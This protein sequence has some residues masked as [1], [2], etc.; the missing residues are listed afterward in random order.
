[1]ENSELDYVFLIEKFI[2]KSIPGYICL[3][4]LEQSKVT[5]TF[6]LPV[7]QGEFL[8]F[9]VQ[10]VFELIDSKKGLVSDNFECGQE[11]FELKLDKPGSIT[12]SKNEQT[13]TFVSKFH[14]LRFVHCIPIMACKAAVSSHL[15]RPLTCFCRSLNN[16]ENWA[17]VLHAE[18]DFALASTILW[19][20]LAKDDND[21]VKTNILVFVEINSKFISSLLRVKK[22]LNE[23]HAQSHKHKRD[24]GVNDG[25][26][27]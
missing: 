27:Q 19:D 20:L 2:V 8:Y 11:K 18:N 7:F 14:F 25:P 26:L 15:F 9:L 23:A 16:L 6:E 5:F 10:R 13:Y 21:N 17:E 12:M 1:M 4:S 24:Q 3:G 22:K